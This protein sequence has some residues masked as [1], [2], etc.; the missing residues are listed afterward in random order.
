M[1]QTLGVSRMAVAKHIAGLRQDGYLIAASPRRGYLLEIEAD[2]IDLE[3]IKELLTS[4]IIGRSDWIWRER[5]ASTNQEAIVQAAA[6]AR[7]GSVVLTDC[8]S[9]GRGRQGRSWFSAPRSLY[10]SIIMRPPLRASQ[11]SLLT[12]AAALA[13]QKLIAEAAALPAS[14]KWPNDIMLRQRKLGGVLLEAGLSAGEVDWA[15]VGIGCNINVK[16]SEFP[17]N[18]APL[19]TSTL[20]SGAP[21]LARNQLYAGLLNRLDRYYDLICSGQTGVMLQEWEAASAICGRLI[22]VRNRETTLE[23]TA[24]GLNPDGRLRLLD[25]KGNE[26]LLESGDFC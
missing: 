5:S 24:R 10:L 8:Q 7:D 6:G 21:V 12:T 19:A 15:V 4:K 14:I 11:L 13:T 20:A 22:T 23:G 26:H 16:S 9:N 3:R 18:L 17:A 1:A 25:A 2:A